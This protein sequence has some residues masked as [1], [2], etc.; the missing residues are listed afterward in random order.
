MEIILTSFGSNFPYTFIE[1]KESNPFF[2]MPPLNMGNINEL[3]LPD[4]GVLLFFDKIILDVKTWEKLI[5]IYNKKI[6]A[7][8][9]I[10]AFYSEYYKKIAEVLFEL[11]DNGFV[12]LEDFD[13]ILS[14]NKDLLVKMT[15]HDLQALDPWIEPLK[16]SHTI[17]LNF[18]QKLDNIRFRKSDQEIPD[19]EIH[20]LYQ[21]KMEFWKGLGFDEEF[22]SCYF[23][24][25]GSVTANLSWSYKIVEKIIHS[26]VK[27]L[28]PIYKEH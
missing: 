26:S 16:K 12:R 19:E 17:W 13:E 6:N 11:H 14:S 20:N 18:L 28:D 27:R 21:K 3:F 1:R 10:K 7:D 9:S 15:D 8:E 4:Y 23:H 25:L 2:R 22:T 5:Q 24:R